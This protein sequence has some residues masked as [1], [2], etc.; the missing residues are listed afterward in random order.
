MSTRKK[1]YAFC[2]TVSII[3]QVDTHN[4]WEY[5]N[6]LKTISGI[7]TDHLRFVVLEYRQTQKSVKILEVSS[8]NN[9]VLNDIT[10]DKIESKEVNLF[11][12]KNNVLKS[13]FKNYVL[14]NDKDSKYQMLITWGHGAGFGFFY[15]DYNGEKSQ[16]NITY[17]LDKTTNLFKQNK[18]KLIYRTAQSNFIVANTSPKHD[19][20]YE[21]IE[22]LMKIRCIKGLPEDY[23][24]QDIV[25]EF[26]D[27]TKFLSVEFFASILKE[28]F[29]DSKK[30]VNVFI[31]NNCYSNMFETGYAL[32]DIVEVFAASQSVVPFAGVN[33]ST[34]FDF[35]QEASQMEQEDE[36]YKMTMEEM[37]LNI[38]DTF[39]SR[40]IEG[41]FSKDFMQKRPN[42]N[43]R[44]FS[45]SVNN[46]ARYKTP[47]KKS[48]TNENKDPKDSLSFFYIINAL[49]D[50]LIKK[51]QS[52]KKSIFLKKIDIARSFCGDFAQGVGFIDFTNFFCELIKTFQDEDP[53]ELKK[54]YKQFF[55]LKEE[56][57]LSIINPGELFRFMP[58]S[59]YSQSPQLFSIFFPSRFKRSDIINEFMK[60]YFQEFGLQ[61]DKNTQTK[62]VNEQQP[63][64]IQNGSNN[65]KM[66]NDGNESEEL[67]KDWKW[68][69]FLLA[70][71]TSE[72]EQNNE[73]H[74]AEKAVADV[75]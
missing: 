42:I 46:L 67:W 29:G 32:S 26:W 36:K 48:K 43:P 35:L 31:S 62:L 47:D 60:L 6:L 58:D 73:N 27:R 23:F 14:D 25:D 13:F 40:Y 18:Y 61:S 5:S 4:E 9:T 59:F 19:P 20:S 12:K 44:Q 7:E 54:L 3:A 37:A 17:K 39:I 10:D 74:P 64:L 38:T 72:N 70:Y 1:Q 28:T 65:G 51:L 55:F 41:K 57:L 63:I 50:Y 69:E 56:T 8:K 15:H 34:L 33:Y 16:N 52:S 49:A 24:S 30:K 45:L 66:K 11:D 22:N 71:W 53:G 2:W 75:P 21:E 68:P